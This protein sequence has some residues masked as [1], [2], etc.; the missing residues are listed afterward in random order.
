[1]S[2]IKTK[3]IVWGYKTAS[4]LAT[5]VPVQISYPVVATLGEMYYWVARSHSRHADENLRVVLDE[6]KVNRRVRYFARKSFRNYSKYMVDLLRQPNL[7]LHQISRTMSAED[8][9]WDGVKTAF[10]HGKGAVMV[11]FHFGN[12]DAAASIVTSRGV[13]LLAVVKDF[14]PP[15]LNELIQ[16]ARVGK[17]MNVL[18]LKE[19]FKALFAQ[20]KRNQAIV[21]ML[22]SPTQNEGIVVDFFGQ[23][24]RFPM[25][26]AVMA[27]R[28]GAPIVLGY[29][30]RQ[31]GTNYYWGRF[32]SPIFYQDTGDK[33][34]DLRA[35]T[36]NLAKQVEDAVR[37]NPDQW[38]M[39]R[40][41]FLTPEEVAEHAQQNGTKTRR[42]SE[43]KAGSR[44]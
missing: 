12:W 23:P 1:M 21:L 32:D 29:I 44:A 43:R 42:A 14:E 7:S 15:E 22:D 25:G 10:A 9:I 36:Q 5:N 16:S 24:A 39:F 28:T 20:L 13:P 33:T 11:S 17:G 37:R 38:Y 35:C 31:P 4:W 8:A 19:S 34:A 41:L 40:K 6:P 27:Q 2:K 18:T 3:T 26:P 30:A